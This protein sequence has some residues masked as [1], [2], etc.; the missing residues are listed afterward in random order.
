MSA[1]RGVLKPG[2]SLPALD[3]VP[4]WTKAKAANGQSVFV[5]KRWTDV[6]S[7]DAPAPAP[8]PVAADIPVPLLEAGH[9]VDWWFVFKQNSNKFPGCGGN[10]QRACPFGG[11]VHNA[12]FGQ[13]FVFA[14]SDD[15]HL[16]QGS[17]C[18]GT[19]ISDPIGATFDEVY[20]R[21]FHFVVWNDQF[22]GDPTV[23]GCSADC[24]SP[25]AH[26]KGMLAWNDA[27]TGLVMQVTTPSWPGAG[28]QA[29]PRQSEGNTLGCQVRNNVLFSQ[30]FF[31]LRVTKDDLV[32]VL[33]GLENASIGT[34]PGNPQIVNNGGPADVQTLVQQLGHKSTSTTAT[35]QTLSSGVR[36]ISKPS[37]LHVPPWQMVS[38]LLGGVPLRA[39]TWWTD[40]GALPSTTAG[41]AI[42]CWD[43]SLGAAG[44]VEIATSGEWNGT[45]IGLKGGT[46]NGNHAKFAVSTDA[47]SHLAIVGDM[48]QTGALSG[49]ASVCDNSQNG[50]GGLFFVVT[51]AD[52]ASSVADLIHGD[53]APVN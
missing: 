23:T 44:A 36:L 3:S 34:D 53:S 8:G 14:S 41:T 11:S 52:L 48:N 16:Q 12:T 21:D 19:T 39:A 31:A 28:N 33:E 47:D 17:G 9:A 10:V 5:S 51:D 18:V 13:Q 49:P 40:P 35:M 50:R 46:P 30:H 7:C 27:G 26:S 20:H 24:A 25:W 22:E 29:H 38:S 43:A 6:A 45:S 2:E 15:R 42:G 4:G 37:R 1:R 32:K